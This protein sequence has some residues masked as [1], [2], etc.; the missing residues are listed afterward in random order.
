MNQKDLYAPGPCGSGKKFKFCCYQEKREQTSIIEVV[1]GCGTYG[2]DELRASALQVL[3]K[4][5][6]V[7]KNTSLR[8]LVNGVYQDIYLQAV[9]L[10]EDY[11][12]CDLPPEKWLEVY[13]KADKASRKWRPNWKAI[14]EDYLSLTQAV[15][16]FVPGHFTYAAEMGTKLFC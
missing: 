2:S 1:S 5:G 8:M 3:Q 7:E 14:G 13:E 16:E 12:F 15:P 4:R 9:S 6:L 11:Q 10:N